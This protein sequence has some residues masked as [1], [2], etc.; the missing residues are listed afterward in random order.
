MPRLN[1]IAECK[2]CGEPSEGRYCPA[3]LDVLTR[4]YNGRVQRQ[5]NEEWSG[6]SNEATSIDAR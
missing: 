4:Y 6:E 3:C 2:E 1:L 5:E